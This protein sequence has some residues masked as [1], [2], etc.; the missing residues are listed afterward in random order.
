L[1]PA[2]SAGTLDAMGHDVLT[3]AVMLTARRHVDYGRIR[4]ALCPAR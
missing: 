1:A 3:G 4:S 2:A